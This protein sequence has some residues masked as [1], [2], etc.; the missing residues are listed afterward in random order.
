MIGAIVILARLRK[1]RVNDNSN[2][3]RGENCRGEKNLVRDTRIYRV[4][5]LPRRRPCRSCRKIISLRVHSRAIPLFLIEEVA[6]SIFRGLVVLKSSQQFLES[7]CRPMRC[8]SIKLI[9]RGNKTSNDRREPA[10]PS[11]GGRYQHTE[12]GLVN[13]RN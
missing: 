8:N 9:S 11:G 3:R 1:I 13:R 2:R 10:R 6:A 4:Y 12:G 7:V 5:I